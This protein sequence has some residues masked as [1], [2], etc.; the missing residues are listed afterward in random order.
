MI[1]SEMQ[2]KLT[3][4]TSGFAKAMD[5]ASGKV[6]TFK[7]R[8]SKVGAALKGFAMQ[9]AAAAAVVSGLA[10]GA[11]KIFDLGASI[12]ETG[13]KF[14]TVFGA[15]A[16]AEVSAFLD[17]FANK[18]G[19]TANEA[20]GMVATTGAIAQ[21]L[22]FTQKASGEAAIE[23]AKL[24]GDLSSFNNIPT[25]ET[26]HAVNSALTGEREQLKRLGIVILEAD[27]QAQ[28]FANTGKTVA[29]ELT[30]QEKATASLQLITE[31]AGVAVGDL[32]R[33]SGSAAN[34][35]RRLKARFLE[36]RDAIA[37]ALMPAFR[38]IL[39]GIEDSEGGLLS[40]KQAILDNTGAISAWAIVAI[41]GFQMVAAIIAVPVRLVKNMADILGNMWRILKAIWE[42]DWDAVT[43]EMVAGWENVKDVGDS[44]VN[45]WRSGADVVGAIGDAVS[46]ANEKFGQLATSVNTAADAMNNL[47]GDDEDDSPIAPTIE[48]V[49][50]LE[51]K[52][53]DLSE[54]FSK[55]FVNRMTTAAQGGKDAFKGYFAYMKKQL[56]ALAMKA[57]LFKAIMGVA[58]KFGLD[59]GG[60]AKSMTGFEVATTAG[61][62]SSLPGA[63]GA[64]TPILSGRAAAIPQGGTV[65]NQNINF[66]VSAIDGRSA[67]RFIK[68]QGGA[69]AEVVAT[70]AKDSTAYRRQLQ[71]A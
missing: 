41:E 45:V 59:L 6:K 2:V 42:R 17:N 46:G 64:G 40:F 7:D 36:I 62:T 55:N 58:G 37:T 39:T 34:V 65:V 52:L 53:K 25:A 44:V 26:I 10:W 33:T 43:D 38:H 19:L 67:A 69:I 8:T 1:I 31:K 4:S 3:A 9:A 22:G 24:A 20:K 12:A 71:G 68:E 66:T 47:G 28:A 23:I 5:W 13:S 49:K 54:S 27:V 63:P 50:T 32:D 60:F 61:D 30:Q 56:I 18:A 11:K 29:K 14:N 15:E 51:D 48:A 57:L 35:F 16:S 21:G 70:A